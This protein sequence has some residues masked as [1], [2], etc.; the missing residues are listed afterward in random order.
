METG[1]DL[2]IFSYTEKD[3][4]TRKSG[5]KKTGD[6]RVGFNYT[7]QGTRPRESGAKGTGEGRAFFKGRFKSPTV[8]SE[9]KR[10]RSRA[11]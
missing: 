8:G 11:L 3:T 2:V 4:R 6:G 1:E 5:A 9:G 7:E 10:K